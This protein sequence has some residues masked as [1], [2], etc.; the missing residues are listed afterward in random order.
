MQNEKTVFNPT[1]TTNQNRSIN[2]LL[3]LSFFP[4]H[5]RNWIGAYEN[6][7]VSY[8]VENERIQYKYI[9][10]TWHCCLQELGEI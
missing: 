8:A 10:D 9:P 7:Q 2:A 6:E 4:A 3:S 1:M 5:P